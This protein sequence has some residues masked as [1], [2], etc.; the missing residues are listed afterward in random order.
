M[1]S[2]DVETARS[3]IA[4]AAENIAA[5]AESLDLR[6]WGHSTVRINGASGEYFTASYI[7]ELAEPTDCGTAACIAGHIAFAA[8]EHFLGGCW[9][10]SNA[11]A[12]VLESANV[13]SRGVDSSGL[14][15][16][17]FASSFD[18]WPSEYT[19]HL[20]DGWDNGSVADAAVSMLDDIANGEWFDAVSE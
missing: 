7:D 8:R 19:R 15:Y 16:D 10:I 2:L 5:E 11:A 12:V 14:E 9:H 18:G 17:L 4:K 1:N 13:Q 3:I 6:S 20:V